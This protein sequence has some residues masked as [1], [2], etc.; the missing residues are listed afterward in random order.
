[1]DLVNELPNGP[2]LKNP[3]SPNL[4]QIQFS[5][6]SKGISEVIFLTALPFFS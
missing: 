1:M 4:I 5:G 6:I 3:K 2:F